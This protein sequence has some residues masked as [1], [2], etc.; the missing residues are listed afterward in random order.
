MNSQDELRAKQIIEQLRHQQQAMAQ[1][2]TMQPQQLPQ[3]TNPGGVETI[4]IPGIGPV[5]KGAEISTNTKKQNKQADMSTDGTCPQ[6]GTVHP[7][8]Q[9]GH[10][11][12]MA[13]IE[14][15]TSDGNV[16]KINLSTYLDKVRDIF[17]GQLEQKNIKDH[18]AF[19]KYLVVEIT[20]AI[21]RY[22]E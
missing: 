14:S 22:K 8:I 19:M 9:P 2:P 11:C 6:C 7:P 1:N 10:T 13:P 15:K 18:D 4:D 3:P 12:P 5:I 17:K 20:K 21:E 16:V